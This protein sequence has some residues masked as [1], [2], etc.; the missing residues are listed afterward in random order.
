M[1]PVY[2]T[3]EARTRLKEIQNYLITQHAPKAAKKVVVMFLSR[4]QQIEIL[5][6][7]HY[8]QLLP[9]TVNALRSKHKNI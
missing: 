6:I 1:K 4:T 5:T 9:A 2:W 7:M 8:R 3:P